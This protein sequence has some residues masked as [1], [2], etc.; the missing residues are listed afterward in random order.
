MVSAFSLGDQIGLVWSCTWPL[1]PTSVH[2]PWWAHI[3]ICGAMEE[4][5][6]VIYPILAWIFRR[7]FC[8]EGPS[9]GFSLSQVSPLFYFTE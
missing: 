4:Q 6:Q 7:L 3:D 1:F 5:D 2:S 8:F 9:A